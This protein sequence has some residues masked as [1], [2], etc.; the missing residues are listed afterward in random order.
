[1]GGLINQNTGIVQAINGDIVNIK[2]PRGGTVT[3]PNKGFRI[4]QSVCLII[5]PFGNSVKDAIP[6]EK[7]KDIIQHNNDGIHYPNQLSTEEEEK[8]NGNIGCVHN[9]R[10][11]AAWCID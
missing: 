7:A 3:A 2:M 6:I 10:Q 8:D 4:G 9:Y 11:I 1:M 5:G